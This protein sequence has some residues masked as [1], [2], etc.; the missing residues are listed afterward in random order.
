MEYFHE[1]PDQLHVNTLPNRAYYLSFPTREAALSGAPS[2]RITLLNGTWDFA[3]FP[4]IE[5]VPAQID[6]W[7]SIPV[8]AVWQN[9]GYDRHQ[10]SNVRYTIPYDPPYVPAENPCGVYRR[11]FALAKQPGHR[12]CLNFEGVDSCY[13]LYV[14]G[15]FAGFSQVSHST[16]E[17]DITDLLIDGENTL[18]VKVLKWC[19]GTYLED[20]DK[21]R[22]SGIFRDVYLIERPARYLRDFFVHTAINPENDL[23][24]ARVTVDLECAGGDTPVSLTLI[25]PGGE[26]LSPGADGAFTVKN[27]LLWTAETPDLYTLLLE[28]PDECIAKR[29]GIRKVEVKGGILLLNGAPIRL[30]GVN[31]HDSDP[32]TG[33]TISREQMIRDMRLMK[34]HNV[35]AI[36]TSHYP[37]APW[38]PELCDQYGFYLMAE[39]DIES[40]G[41]CTLY[42]NKAKPSDHR[43]D[44]SILS[45]D[46]RFA[47]AMLDRVQ[48][49]VHRDKNSPSVL[50]WSM[51]NE[52]G[53]GPNMEAAGR[54][55]KAFDPGRLTHYEGM[56]WAPPLRDN[57]NRMFDLYSRMYPTL[58]DIHAHFAGDDGRPMV[59]C[60]YI[61]AMGNG[62]GD[63]E[64]YE[65]LFARYPGFCGGFV[66]E[67][68]DHGI[69][70]GT[71][72][73]GKPIY[74][75]GGDSGET[76][77]D[78][79]FCM[80][81]LV[82]P[83]RRPHTGFAEYKNVIRP[84]RAALVPGDV[85]MIRLMNRMDF[86]D[87]D[88]FAT[89]RYCLTRNGDVV[90]EGE[91]PLTGGIAPRGEALF[92]LPCE[93]PAN[94]LCLLTLTSYQ[95]NDLP[96]TPKGH[97]LGVDQLVLRE[98]RVL[99]AIAQVAAFGF[100]GTDIPR[101]FNP[102]PCITE[103]ARTI[104][105]DGD[106]F[107]YVF[108]KQTGLFDTMCHG[109]RTLLAK[110]MG[111]NIWRA[112][113]DN[114]K[115]ISQSW[116][117]AGYD[118]AQVRVYAVQV[119]AEGG[120]VRIKTRAG[121]AAVSL[122]KILDI[123]TA[124][125][126][127][128]LGR[129]RIEMNGKRNLDMPFL[130][131]FGLRLFLLEAV[132][133]AEYFGYGPYESY[134]DKHR[135]STRGRFATTP[136]ANHEDY[137]RPQENGSHWGCEYLRAGNL[138]A[139][140]DAP[141]SFNISPYTQEELTQKKH[142]WELT[143]SGYTV[144]CLDYKHSGIGSN[145]C[146]PDL[147]EKY[148]FDEET[149]TFALTLAAE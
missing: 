15:Q 83:D 147:L 11:R 148:R 120:A 89:M 76:P 112:P 22:M 78:E 52:S 79:N 108:N 97:P 6:I 25:T 73:E 129:V 7:D 141:F 85:P 34:A 60:E 13:Y 94:G 143:P 126:I 20:Q 55:T 84:I 8:P 128:A 35:N 53:F 72:P 45:L 67:F 59:L 92:P 100:I 31:R 125:T 16:S 105:I 42:H 140:A 4:C 87:A 36:R 106:N 63:A 33:F 71:T 102:I 115:Y 107:S 32:V 10:Y 138:F 18:L 91:L 19:V 110:P 26:T 9:H 136:W 24:T 139:Y 1:N 122:Q 70:R 134:P 88:T 149:F 119:E 124:F 103:T 64:D 116:K 86:C 118:R 96:L 54:W 127:D 114:D 30:R 23:D 41:T 61:H 82:Y 57:D 135:A 50:I 66:W 17:F 5:A 12:Y 56:Y 28:T 133:Q 117:A 99:P 14:N 77:P 48:R 46:P 145:S 146:G 21:F 65:E 62:P 142:N 137:I 80:D 68:C 123:E 113:T 81:G 101:G 98:G 37:N 75:Y 49:N 130:P 90:S 74:A 104:Q 47:E 131:R 39:S 27:P 40:H 69:Y 93:I 51:G 43:D 144:L 38:M 3:Y 132:Q 58:A 111:Y 29:I 2:P 95:K 44:F 121:L 109:Q